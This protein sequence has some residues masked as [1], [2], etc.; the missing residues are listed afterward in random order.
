MRITIVTLAA[1]GSLACLAPS[2]PAAEPAPSSDIYIYASYLHCSQAVLE[3]ADEAV[4]KLFGPDLDKMIKEGARGRV[5][6]SWGWLAKSTG[7]EWSRAGY[8]TGPSL[9]DVLGAGGNL[10]VMTD[11]KPPHA[12]RVAFDKA[13]PS[14]EDY[15]WRVVAGNDAR[16]HR[17]KAAFSTYYVCDQS[18]ET[19]ADALVKRVLAPM[20]DKMV[21][22]HK[23]VTWAW[24][25]HI[26]GG[27]YRRLGTMSASTMEA[28]IK[29]R[30]EIV[31]AA[32]HDPIS[33]AITSICGSHQDY[34]WD[35]QREG[36]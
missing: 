27:K 3:Q 1:V 21:A 7:G 13:C 18:R 25:E 17:G 34:I 26:V 24:A 35:V 29:A 5:V 32:E 28:L 33:E 4:A 30:Q 11:G 36:P 22:D 8:L 12:E 16:G 6:G 2:L 20:Y 9:E 15:I 19:Q 23:L 14:S 10:D 31:A